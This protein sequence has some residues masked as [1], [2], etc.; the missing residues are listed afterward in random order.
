MRWLLAYLITYT[1]GFTPPPYCNRSFLEVTEA[2]PVEAKRYAVVLNRHCYR[3]FSGID[4]RNKDSY[5]VLPLAPGVCMPKEP[6]ITPK[7]PCIPQNCPVKEP[8]DTQKRP[9]DTCAP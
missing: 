3:G 8:Y 2:K 4:Y 5:V 7:E 9:T 1:S 6:R